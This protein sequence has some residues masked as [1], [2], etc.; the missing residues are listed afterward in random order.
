MVGPMHALF[1]GQLH[2]DDVGPPSLAYRHSIPLGHPLARRAEAN[3][4]PAR[5]TWGWNRGERTGKGWV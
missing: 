4:N 3:G 2:A 1:A 5:K